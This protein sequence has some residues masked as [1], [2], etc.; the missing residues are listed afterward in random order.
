LST[1]PSLS[2]KAVDIGKR[3]N[4]DNVVASVAWLAPVNA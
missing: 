2:E 4:L 3:P 1:K